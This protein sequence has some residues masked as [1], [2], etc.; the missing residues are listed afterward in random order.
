M[1]GGQAIDM[2]GGERAGFEV[3]GSVNRYDYGLVWALL[4]EAGAIIL[5]EEVKIHANIELVKV[6]G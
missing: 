1:S 5:G 2:A 4:T 6:N 3:M